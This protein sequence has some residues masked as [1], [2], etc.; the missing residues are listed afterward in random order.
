LKKLYLYLLVS[1]PFTLGAQ[2]TE[3]VKPGF[4]IGFNLTRVVS[5][6]SS[7][8]NGSVNSQ[9]VP[10]SFIVKYR[11]LKNKGAF[12]IGAASSIKQKSD[13]LV[14]S[15]KFI[16]DQL[17]VPF[18]GYEW[19]KDIS[20]KFVFY[21]GV[22]LR[23]IY[24]SE[25]TRTETFTSSPITVTNNERGIGGG[26]FYGFMWNLSNRISLYT[27]GSLNL[28]YIQRKR[29]FDIGGATQVLENSN[30]LSIVPSAPVSLYMLV[31]F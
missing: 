22:D 12:R 17:V 24:N 23:Y 19:R 10:Y 16:N 20:N 25:N 18:V 2:T 15:T 11:T 21:G 4:E 31:R 13:A 5:S 8:N 7:N 9:N 1:L 3:V 27:E 14:T 6:L 26:P 28:N 30:N 29:V